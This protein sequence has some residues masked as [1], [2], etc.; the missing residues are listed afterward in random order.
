MKLFSVKRDRPTLLVVNSDLH[1]NSTVALCP[2]VIELDDGGSYR[3]SKVQLHLWRS[4]TDFWSRIAQMKKDLNADVW[5]VF[6]GDTADK[7]SHRGTQVIT[8]NEATINNITLCT[9][10]PALAITD[11]LFFIRGTPAHTGKSSYIEESLAED[12]DAYPDDDTGNYSWWELPLTVSGVTFHIAHHRRL[13]HL[14]WT[15]GGA[16]NRLAAQLVYEYADDPTRPDIAIRSHGH[17]IDESSLT[18]PIK[19]I[20]TPAWQ[21][22]TEFVYRIASESLSH[23]GGLVFT[24]NKGAYSWQWIDRAYQPTRRKPITPTI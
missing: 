13:T 22:K 23:I 18:H 17:R 3:A 20:F 1:C 9:L 4:W 15:H 12:L 24:C 10:D 16:A 2:P 11:L 21:L 8:R 6:N 5:S 14:P 19:V 7:D